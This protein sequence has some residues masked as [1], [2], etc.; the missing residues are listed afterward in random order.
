MCVLVLMGRVV[1]WPSDH[2]CDSVDEAEYVATAEKIGKRVLDDKL[3]GR[4]FTQDDPAT[5]V[6]KPASV[7]TE[8]PELPLALPKLPSTTELPCA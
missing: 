2:W 4:W 7:E 1:L 3:K 6:A 5:H 8:L